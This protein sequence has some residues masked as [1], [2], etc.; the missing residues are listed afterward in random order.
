MS[1]SIEK[2]ATNALRRFDGLL[3]PQAVSIFTPFTS[4]VPLASCKITPC[5]QAIPG[6][7]RA[8]GRGERAVPASGRLSQGVLQG[9]RQELHRHHGY[10]LREESVL[11]GLRR[12]ST[13]EG[14]GR[15]SLVVLPD[16]V[17]MW[18][19]AERLVRLSDKKTLAYPGGQSTAYG[20]TIKVGK[21]AIGWTIWHG[22]GHGSTFD[23]VMDAHEQSDTF[24]QPASALQRST[25]LTSACSPSGRT[26][27]SQPAS[28]AWL[29]MSAVPTTGYSGRTSTTS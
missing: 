18:G 29:S 25:R 15:N 17:L 14:E 3:H 12:R 7:L 22:V 4:P 20:G 19:Q 24:V 16:P 27:T 6:R 8:E 10:R 21:E 2:V 13:D 1:R 11:P 5:A 28:G 26:R 9:Q 23:R